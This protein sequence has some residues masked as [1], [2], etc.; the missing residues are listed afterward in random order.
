[1]SLSHISLTLAMKL[2]NEIKHR[3]YEYIF[4]C[5]YYTHYITCYTCVG[6]EYI[7]TCYIIVA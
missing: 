1:M 2:R 3:I 4:M 5:I 7:S 6:M